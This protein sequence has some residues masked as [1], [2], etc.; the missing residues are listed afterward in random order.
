M[1]FGTFRISKRKA[2]K[3][4]NPHTGKEIEIPAKKVPKFTP[5]KILKNAVK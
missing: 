4:R 3:G 5:G 1:G 2:R